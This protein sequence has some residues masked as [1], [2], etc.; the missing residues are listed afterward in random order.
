MISDILR[1]PFVAEAKSPDKNQ[2][3]EGLKP[4]VSVSELASLDGTSFNS[5]FSCSSRSDS[6]FHDPF[7]AVGVIPKSN[8]CFERNWSLTDVK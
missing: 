6:F 7:D 5:G 1:W 3:P 8:P 4:K 2:S